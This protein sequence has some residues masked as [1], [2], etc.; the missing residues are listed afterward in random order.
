VDAR[1]ASVPANDS[2]SVEWTLRNEYSGVVNLFAQVPALTNAAAGVL[3]RIRSDGK[4][5]GE[6]GFFNGLPAGQWIYIGTTS[7]MLARCTV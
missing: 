5:L 2:V 7:V 1:T 6:A 3:F 4:V